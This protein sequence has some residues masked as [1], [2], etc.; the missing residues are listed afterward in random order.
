M[1]DTYTDKQITTD[2]CNMLAQKY[3]GSIAVVCDSGVI[4]VLTAQYA[5]KVAHVSKWKH[6]VG[7]SLIHALDTSCKPA[8]Y[9]FDVNNGKPTEPTY[10]TLTYM[11]TYLDKLKVVLMNDTH[12]SQPFNMLTTE[13]IASIVTTFLTYYITSI[14]SLALNRRIWG[15]A[16]SLWPTI[17]RAQLQLTSPV[18]M[19]LGDICKI[20]L[21]PAADGP[22]G[23]YRIS[24]LS[25][26]RSDIHRYKNATIPLFEVGAEL[27]T[28]RQD[29]R[30]WITLPN[31]R[32]N[33]VIRDIRHR[34]V[35]F[36]RIRDGKIKSPKGIYTIAWSSSKDRIYNDVRQA[37]ETILPELPNIFYI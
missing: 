10:D 28:D 37:M 35:S 29:S 2:V 21:P 19:Q 18:A 16:R 6:A 24:L 8:V 32:V 30:V 11:S 5:I 15:I 4:D 36:Q 7:Q 14:R 33:F 3:T 23:I 9:F 22:I 20:L 13:S 26:Y 31:Y 1:E 25:D 27:C 34:S 17:I 12:I